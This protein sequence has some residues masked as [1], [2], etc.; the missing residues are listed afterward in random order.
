MRR[1]AI[2]LI[3]LFGLL[4]A[5]TA[6]QPAAAP[7][8]QNTFARQWLDNAGKKDVKVTKVVAG[9]PKYHKADALWCVETEAKTPEG[10]SYLVAVWRTGQTWAGAQLVDGEYEWD[11]NGCPRD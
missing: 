2:L 6:C 3:V 8:D 4:I 7:I 5:V 1:N 11:L 9:N 10:A